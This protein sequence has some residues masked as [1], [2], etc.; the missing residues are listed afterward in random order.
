M[1]FRHGPSFAIKFL[2]YATWDKLLTDL[3]Y[4]KFR[5]DDPIAAQLKIL[6]EGTYIDI[7]IPKVLKCLKS[8]EMPL[9]NILYSSI[10]F[11]S[12]STDG[13]IHYTQSD[14][15][16]VLY[17]LRLKA[18]PFA[19]WCQ[20]NYNE[21]LGYPGPPIV[22]LSIWDYFCNW[23]CFQGVHHNSAY[24]KWEA[25]LDIVD[26]QGSI[27]GV[28]TVAELSEP[29]KKPSKKEWPAWVSILAKNLVPIEEDT[30]SVVKSLGTQIPTTEAILN[31]Q[32]ATGRYN[33]HHTYFFANALLQLAYA[34]IYFHL[35]QPDYPTLTRDQQLIRFKA[36]NDECAGIFYSR[37]IIKIGDYCSK[38]EEH[39][40]FVNWLISDIINVDADKCYTWAGV[41]DPSTSKVPPLEDFFNKSFT[42]FKSTEG[43]RLAIEKR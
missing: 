2:D 19:V 28:P 20:T 23:T 1:T 35:A 37:V 11:G 21:R 42:S 5:D 9:P 32:A 3:N 41:L 27:I 14:M 16:A 8:G 15:Q 4:N 22:S 36:I 40:G 10:Q 33:Y 25:E 7:N 6:L 34:A 13:D 18:R 30:S 38:S 39:Y 17:T 43:I 26:V 24:C 29:P 12:S 31:V